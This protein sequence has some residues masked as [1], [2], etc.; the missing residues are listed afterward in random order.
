MMDIRRIQE[1]E[2]PELLELYRQLNPE[3]PILSVT[4]DLKKIWQDI[5][6]DPDQM[7]LCITEN[8]RLVSVCTL[9]MLKNLTRGAR[10]F[11]LIENVVTH[12]DYRKRGYGKKLLLYAV[13]LARTNNCFK[14]MLMSG[15]DESTLLFYEHIGF[16]RTKKTAFDWRFSS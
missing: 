10:P 11:A 13:E 5:L 7:I 6:A 9:V 3:D 4:A 16:D 8:N 12:S 1:D 2:L 15:R 14:V